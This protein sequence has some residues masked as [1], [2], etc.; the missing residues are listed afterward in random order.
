MQPEK[1]QLICLKYELIIVNKKNIKF[2][3]STG[4]NIPVELIFVDKILLGKGH[5]K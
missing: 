4:I 3:W 2:G 5:L 1:Y